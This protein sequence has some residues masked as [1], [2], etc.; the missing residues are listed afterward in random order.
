[1]R[2][3][4]LGI[5]GTFMGGIAAIARTL[6]H[7]VSGSD[8]NVY[9]PMSDQLAQ[10]G[11]EIHSGYDVSPLQNEALDE[12]IVGNVMTRGMAATE[13]MLENSTKYSSGP[14]WLGEQVLRYKKVFAVAGTHGKTTTSS[15]LAWIL[16]DNNINP[17]FL[18]GGVCQ[19]FPQSARVT[20]SEA[21]VLEADEYDSAFFDKRSKFVHYHS[22]VVVLNNLEF[23]HADIFKD[24]EAIKTQFHHLVRTIPQNGQ[25]IVNGDDKN[26]QAVL[27]QGC[28]TPVV[29]FGTDDNSAYWLKTHANNPRQFSIH[30]HSGVLAE[31]NW[32]ITGKHNQLNALAAIL[33]ARQAGV[34][35]DAAA[36]S[37]AKFQNVKRRMEL[38]GEVKGISIYDD[39]AHHPTAIE[40]TLA[41]LKAVSKGRTIAVLELRS[42]SMRDGAHAADLPQALSGSDQAYV[43]IY[44]GMGWDAEIK[45]QLND[46]FVV[47]D[48]I[49]NLLQRLQNDL[50]LND[51]VVFMSNGSFDDAPRRLLQCLS[52]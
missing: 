37:I 35:I 22:D 7:Q 12:V 36:Q 2:I 23:D 30:D 26:L 29:S 24:L 10:L 27:K 31:I 42:N 5:C 28:W 41:G 9:P 8:Q 34:S 38:I 46:R 51:N 49:E 52:G 21:F 20:E 3:H 14:Q 45:Q 13:Y 16:E 47:L 1:M 44:P 50:R 15:M 43:M 17:G 25:I 19:H 4:I 40:T 48:S 11:I 6:G 32:N 33:A 18:I 39:F